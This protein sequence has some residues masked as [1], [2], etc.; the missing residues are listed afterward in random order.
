MNKKIILTLAIVMVLIAMPIMASAAS[1]FGDVNGTKYESPVI[2]LTGLKVVN[3]FPDGTFKPNN[4]VTRAQ[5]AKMIVESLNLKNVTEVVLTQFSDVNTTHWFY[6]FVKTAVDNNIIVGYPDGTFKPNSEVT[7]A[8]ATTMIVRA[9][10]LEASMKDKTWPTAYITL[11]NSLGFLDNVAYSNV[12]DPATRGEV[13]VELYNMVLKNEADKEKEELAKIEKEMKE[14]EEAKKKAYSFGIVTD[15]STGTKSTYYVKLNE[16]KS[17]Q[18]VTSI[19]G[20]SK[21]T[22]SK[23]EALEN[24]LIAYRNSDDGIDVEVTYKNTIFDKAKII[25]SVSNNVVTFKDGDSWDLSSSSIK[26][27]YRLYQF[28]RVTCEYDEDEDGLISFEK[29]SDLGIGITNASF[30]KSERVYIDSTNKVVVIAK[31]F[32]NSDTIKN[33]KV[34]SDDEDTSEYSYG[35]VT[36]VSDTSKTYYAKIDRV[37]YV[38]PSKYLDEVEEDMYLVFKEK[39]GEITSIVESYSVYDLDSKAE[40]V[41]TTSGKAGEQVIRYKDSSK[42][43]DYYTKSN[44]TKYKNYKIVVFEIEPT[45]KNALK[46]TNHYMESDL[47]DITFTKGDRTIVDSKTKVFALFTGL[48]KDDVVK[49]GKYQSAEEAEKEAEEEANKKFT[50]KYAWATGKS[51]K[52]VTLPASETVKNGTTYTVK[53]PTDARYS[54]TSSKGTSFKVTGNT[55]IYI[56]PKAKTACKVTYSLASGSATGVVTLPSEATVYVGDSYT[57]KTFSASGYTI[58]TSPSG[59]VTVS[60]NI[61]VVVT[62]KKSQEEQDKEKRIAELEKQI[63]ELRSAYNTA[64]SESDAAKSALDSANSTLASAKSAL[65]SKKTAKEDAAEA[66]KTAKE[67]LNNAKIKRSDAEDAYN[68][69]KSA[70]D[71][72]TTDEE[73]AELKPALDKASQNL[74]TAKSEVTYADADVSAKESALNKANTA[75]ETAQSDYNSAEAKQKAAQSTYD[76]KIAITNSTKKALDD[77]EKELADLKK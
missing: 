61:N 68:S 70:Y 47:E 48:E 41:Y 72:A 55:T 30:S 2:K 73:R 22:E 37:E 62:V 54:Y 24:N 27:T 4:K 5:M 39:N 7:Y 49:K 77:A 13:A 3:G 8:E 67:T 33:G 53:F 23:L 9:M 16:L 42:D 58:T 20:S 19:A 45:S 17:K 63:P 18:E 14:V 60:G 44:T 6:P 15:T 59:K 31:G 21:I 10:K 34:N 76:S 11:A 56:T 52:D 71:A 66:L 28:V 36:K 75:L 38:L 57:V 50:V 12:S 32:S 43:V 65:E 51:L 46:V 29:T 1:I 40:I 35:Y 64:K 69:A 25:T 26:S 74:T